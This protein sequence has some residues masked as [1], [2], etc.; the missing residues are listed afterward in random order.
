[1][2]VTLLART[3]FIGIPESVEGTPFGE[4]FYSDI[5]ALRNDADTLS[6]F[7]GRSCY[8]AWKMEHEKT[9]SNM[10]YLENILNQGHESVLE[11]GSATFYIEGVSRNLTHELIRHRHLSYSELSQRFVNMEDANFVI[12]PA[13]R[14][15]ED[16]HVLI[17]KEDEL[18]DHMVPLLHLGLD[19]HNEYTYAVRTL[20][21]EKG[22]THKQARE[23]ARSYLPSGMET[24]IVVSGNHRAWRDMLK[25]RYSTHADA[26]ICELAGLLLESLRE[27][28]PG[29]YQDFPSVP[30]N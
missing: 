5:N 26:E 17:G 11:H 9:A 18:E 15:E 19:R 28:A 8:Q 14:D 7:A 22:K 4:F 29:I 23:A 3:G 13:F 20:Q 2:K 30:F 27:L 21:E 6:H 25:K 1:L 24:R 12:P 16:E 10:G